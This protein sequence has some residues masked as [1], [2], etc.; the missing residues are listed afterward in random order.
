MIISEFYKQRKDGVKLKKTYS[1][2][3]RIIQQ[4]ENGQLYDYAIDVEDSNFTYKET[5]DYVEATP[6]EILGIIL[7][8]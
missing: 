7:G 2:E 8:G 4:M 5:N 3:G 6:Q 1:S